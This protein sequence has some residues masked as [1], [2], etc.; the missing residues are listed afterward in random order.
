[1]THQHKVEEG[2]GQEG[3]EDIE[4][5]PEVALEDYIC[6]Q[7]VTGCSLQLTGRSL[8]MT[9]QHKVEEGEGQ[10]DG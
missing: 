7:Q 9:H 10:E 6:S 3:G 2:E 8:K 5:G 1:M 4:D